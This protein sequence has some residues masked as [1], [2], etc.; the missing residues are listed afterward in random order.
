MIKKVPALGLNGD[1]NLE[2]DS[3]NGGDKLD[4]RSFWRKRQG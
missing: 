2:G 1:I 4:R 3:E